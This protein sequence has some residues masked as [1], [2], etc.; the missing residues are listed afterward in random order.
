MSEE[1]ITSTLSRPLSL[2]VTLQ[3][4]TLVRTPGQTPKV[5]YS[6]AQADYVTL[7]AVTGD[8]RVPTVRQFRQAI[9]GVS[10]ELPGGM[11]NSDEAPAATA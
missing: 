1:L 11:A 5:H 2:W 6:L 10:V 9:R 8:G 3:E 4:R 7:L